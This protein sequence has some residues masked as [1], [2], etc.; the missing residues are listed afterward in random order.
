MPT[1]FKKKGICSW[2]AAA[3]FAEGNQEG[4]LETKLSE[5]FYSTTRKASLPSLKLITD[6]CSAEIPTGI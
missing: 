3:D 6:D 1:L 5:R 4:R 2:R